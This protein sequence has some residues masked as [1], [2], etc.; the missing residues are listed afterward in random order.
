MKISLS[1]LEFEL[2]T[3]FRSAPWNELE[4][5]Q[6]VFSRGLGE[7]MDEIGVGAIDDWTLVCAG[8]VGG[9]IEEM[10]QERKD[11]ERAAR[12]R[13]AKIRFF[14]SYPGDTFKEEDID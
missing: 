7:E 5:F 4:R 14:P 10:L 3:E 9:I 11:K 12:V 2:I 8:N 6:K 1:D 13:T